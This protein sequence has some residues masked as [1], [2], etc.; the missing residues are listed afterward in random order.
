[1]CQSSL[2]MQNYVSE[3]CFSSTIDTGHH[4]WLLISFHWQLTTDY[5]LLTTDYWLRH[6]GGVADDVL[7][8]MDWLMK[9]CLLF[10]SATVSIG[11]PRSLDASVASAVACFDEDFPC[12][13]SC[14][15]FGQILLR[16]CILGTGSGCFPSRDTDA[17]F[18]L[19]AFIQFS[20]YSCDNTVP[21]GLG[22]RQV[23]LQC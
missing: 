4:Q 6:V 5:W 3:W 8:S 11:K 21:A 16:T 12:F 7:I 17:T 19:E 22:V 14:S 1:M 10:I 23:L 9:F 18:L 20:V 2:A 13:L 15:A